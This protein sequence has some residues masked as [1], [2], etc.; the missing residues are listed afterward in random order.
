MKDDRTERATPKRRKEAAERGQSARSQEIGSALV[1]LAVFGIM[2]MTASKSL[3]GTLALFHD[4]YATLPSIEFSEATLRGL[5]FRS[6]GYY[7]GVLAPIMGAAVLIGIVANALQGSVGISKKALSLKWERLNPMTGLKRIY[8]EQA[9]MEFAKSLVKLG[10]LGAIVYFILRSASTKLILIVGYSAGNALTEFGIL[11]LQM[12]MAAGLA[13]LILSIPD[14]VYQRWS[15]EKSIKMSKKEVKDENKDVEGDPLIR[16]RIKTKQA[17]MARQRMMAEVAQ[18]DVVV[19]NPVHVAVALKYMSEEGAPKVLAKGARLV[20]ERIKQMARE[21]GVPVLENPPLARAI[22]K[23]VEI[24]QF[25]PKELY[26][27]VAEVL[28][29][30]YRM[31]K[32][33][34]D[35]SWGL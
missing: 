6:L 3:T 34:K 24:G 33:G 12:G 27:A 32:G 20:A 18:A 7:V 10:I 19:T 28:A 14:L 5:F 22:Y 25:I 13:L 1:L 26:Q 9:L 4:V 21:A 11:A 17:A 16:Q 15:F 31:G 29:F 30:V 23:S 2:A 35:E 8:S